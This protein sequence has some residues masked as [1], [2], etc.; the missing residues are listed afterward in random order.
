MIPERASYRTGA[1]AYWTMMRRSSFA[2]WVHGV[3]AKGPANVRLTSGGTVE[4]HCSPGMIHDGVRDV[5]LNAE[6]LQNCD[7]DWNLAVGEMT[8]EDR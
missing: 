7:C 1:Q 4:V 5:L 3:M 6:C 2:T 8:T